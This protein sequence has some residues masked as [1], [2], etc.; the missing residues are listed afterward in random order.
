MWSSPPVAR[1]RTVIFTVSKIRSVLKLSTTETVIDKVVVGEK[2]KKFLGIVK[3]GDADFVATSEATVKTGVD[4]SKL[5]PKDIRIDGKRI[6]VDLPPIEVL[7]FQYPFQKFKIDENLTN[8]EVFAKI[9][10]FDQ[11][12]F[13]RQAEL[14]IRKNLKYTGIVEQTQI[15]TRKILEGLL[16]N[17]GYNEVYISF[18]ETK[19][20]IQQVVVDDTP[21]EE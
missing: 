8:N 20:L 18:D 9:D 13:Y 12:Y 3:L 6:E 11:E 2:T 14:D 4:L 19:D 17:L 7:D 10:V 5:Q 21:K 16:L 1:T 15:N